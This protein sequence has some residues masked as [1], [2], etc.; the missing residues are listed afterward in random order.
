MFKIG[1]VINFYGRSRIAIVELDGTLAVGDRIRFER[2]G[3]FVCEQ[4][5][6][7]IHVEHDKVD[8]ANRGDV[9]GLKTNEEIKEGDEIF[10]I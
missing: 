2:D 6:E 5:V 9:V 10:K 3:N 7:T 4:K 8:S 1:K